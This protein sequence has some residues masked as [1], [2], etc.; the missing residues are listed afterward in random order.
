MSRKDIKNEVIT[1]LKKEY[2]NWKSVPRKMKKEIAK[3]V[4]EEVVDEYDFKQDITTPTEKLLGIESQ[5]STK[6]IIALDKMAQYI[7][8]IHTVTESSNSVAMIALRSISKMKSCNL[9]IG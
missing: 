3:K 6:G 4:L 9:S 1:Q 2:P 7:E 5:I 8:H